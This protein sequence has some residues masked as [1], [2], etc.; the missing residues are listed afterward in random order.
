MDG[1]S[2]PRAFP[3]PSIS[4]DTLHYVLHPA[5]AS[6]EADL[7][8]LAT[9]ISA[10]VARLLPTPWLWN[11]DAWELKAVSSEQRLEGRMRVGD[12]VDDEWLVVWLLREVSRTWPELVVSIRDSDGE[13]LLIEAAHALPGWV[14]P[15]NAENRV[16]TSPPS[17]TAVNR[18]RSRAGTKCSHGLADPSY[19]CTR[20]IST[21]SPSASRRPRT[22]DRLRT[23]S[24]TKAVGR[25]TR[26][27]GSARRMLSPRCGLGST[28]RPKLK[29]P[30]GK[31]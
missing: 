22:H 25:S 19:G 30:C 23:T 9:L 26:T 29:R 7:A 24:T 31:G 20:A 6:S 27:R 10:H 2:A 21:S 17:S 16:S 1:L 8:A 18:R 15:E 3:L 28:R 11:K 12:A 14:T 5:S 4:E 13:F